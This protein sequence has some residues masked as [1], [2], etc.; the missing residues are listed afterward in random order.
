MKWQQGAACGWPVLLSYP[1]FLSR[2][3]EEALHSSST[4]LKNFLRS[5]PLSSFR[6][7]QAKACFDALLVYAGTRRDK[8]CRPPLNT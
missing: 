4:T 3:A 2:F 6:L 7:Q 1:A 8:V 5:T